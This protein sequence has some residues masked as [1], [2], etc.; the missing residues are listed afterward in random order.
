MRYKAYQD[1][2]DAPSKDKEEATR[3]R[4]QGGIQVSAVLRAKSQQVA[5][6]LSPCLRERQRT[7][8]IVDQ[9]SSTPEELHNILF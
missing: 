7:Y 2:L 5:G 4:R 1:A 9:G 6:D 8:M 3:K